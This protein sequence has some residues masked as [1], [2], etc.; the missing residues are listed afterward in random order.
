MNAEREMSN[1]A[2]YK[3]KF[4]RKDETMKVRQN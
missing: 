4:V 3:N 1:E 2:A